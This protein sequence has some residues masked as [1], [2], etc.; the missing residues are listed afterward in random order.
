MHTN[1]CPLAQ[2]IAL[3]EAKPEPSELTKKV[4]KRVAEYERLRIVDGWIVIRN[5]EVIELCEEIDRLEGE[6]KEQRKCPCCG[7]EGL[8][9]HTCNKS[10][11]K[12]IS[13][14]QERINN[15][16]TESMKY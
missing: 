2:S 6:L 7:Q 16:E 4:R 5:N 15:F 13:E 3:L 11:C 14:L 8:D 9:V 10:Q 1:N 12:T